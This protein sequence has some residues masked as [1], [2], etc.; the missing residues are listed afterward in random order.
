MPKRKWIF[1]TILRNCYFCK[2]FKHFKVDYDT[3]FSD[4][5][6]ANTVQTYLRSGALPLFL[7]T[8]HVHFDFL[9]NSTKTLFFVRVSSISNWSTNQYSVIKVYPTPCKKHLPSDAPPL[10]HLHNRYILLKMMKIKKI[11]ILN[12]SDISSLNMLLDNSFYSRRIII[13]EM[14][15]SRKFIGFHLDKSF[16]FINIFK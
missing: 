2:S 9:Y 6:V 5:S 7:P 11:Y 4:T 12:L 13:L 16:N 15:C 8:Q 10:S 3:I 14:R 1:T